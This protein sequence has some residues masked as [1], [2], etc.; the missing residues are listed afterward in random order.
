MF[1]AILLDLQIRLLYSARRS[2]GTEAIPLAKMMPVYTDTTKWNKL[3]AVLR[4]S[5]RAG[6][7]RWMGIGN[8][9]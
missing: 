9:A 7:P 4:S 5:V 3:T 8:T 2:S 1:D 6:R